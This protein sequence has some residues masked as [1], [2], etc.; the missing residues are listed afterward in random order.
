[1]AN[2]LIESQP[3][4]PPPRQMHAQFLYELALAGNAIQISDQQNAQKQFGINRRSSGL[5]VTV[6]QLCPH[7]LKTDVLV[8]QP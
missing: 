4:E 2:L 3:R 7:K 5:T 6:F 8:D 1:M